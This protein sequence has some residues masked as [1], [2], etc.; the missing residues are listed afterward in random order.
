MSELRYPQPDGRVRIVDSDSGETLRF[1]QKADPISAPFGR[2]GD[3][4]PL[5]VELPADDKPF[6]LPEGTTE[7]AR[8]QAQPSP[9]MNEQMVAQADRKKAGPPEYPAGSPELRSLL[10]LPFRER[11][12][13]MRLYQ[14]AIDAWNNMPTLGTS[15]DTSDKLDRYFGALAA[16]D[17]M[18]FL[19][20]VN[21]DAYRSWQRSVDDSIFA[22]LF[23]VYVARFGLGEAESSSS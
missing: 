6:K 13:A 4:E 23:F 2:N 1:D 7:Q 18:L 9:D 17:D 3:P 10:R 16:F 14:G 12:Q 20:A 11:S 21:P 8:V 19:V 15:L 5:V 22:E